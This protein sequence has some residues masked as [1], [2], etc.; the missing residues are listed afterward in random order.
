MKVSQVNCSK[1][2]FVLAEESEATTRSKLASSNLSKIQSAKQEDNGEIKCACFARRSIPIESRDSELLVRK[3]AERRKGSRIRD[4][5]L[6]DGKLEAT[7]AKS[8]G[9][10][11]SSLLHTVRFTVIWSTCLKVFELLSSKMVQRS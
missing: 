8:P 10:P 7:N 3:K 9:N 5:E 6:A 1:L 2:W 11:F 4:K